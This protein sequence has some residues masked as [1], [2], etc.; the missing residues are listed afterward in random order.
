V[1]S[2]A[3]VLDLLSHELPACVLGAFPS[4]LSRSARRSVVFSGIDLSPVAIRIGRRSC[5]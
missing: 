1:L 5:A 2:L 3:N 4:R